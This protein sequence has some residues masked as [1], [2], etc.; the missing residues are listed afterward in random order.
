QPFGLDRRAVREVKLY[1]G[2]GLLDADADADV[3]S[4]LAEELAEE[5]AGIGMHTPEKLLAALDDRDLGAHARE[6]LRQFAADRAA[7]HND[8]ALWDLVRP[9]RLA[10]RPVLEGVEPIDRRDRRPRARGED[11]PVVRKLLS[12][13]LD[14]AGSRHTSLAADE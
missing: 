7:A 11:E 5:L 14:D 12:V 1:T 2:L 3:D 6:E 9:R 13:H 8:E 4:L 10:V